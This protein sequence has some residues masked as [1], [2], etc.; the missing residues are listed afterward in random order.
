MRFFWILTVGL[1]I[2]IPTFLLAGSSLQFNNQDSSGN[3]SFSFDESGTKINST[4]KYINLSTSTIKN[5]TIN[6]VGFANLT[7]N[8]SDTNAG[9]T[10]N[11]YASWNGSVFGNP[12]GVLDSQFVTY[13]FFTYLLNGS[14]LDSGGDESGIISRHNFTN[15]SF[16]LATSKMPTAFNGSKL[17]L[18]NNTGDSSDYSTFKLM[19]TDFP[20]N[21]INITDEFSLPLDSL[22]T[23]Q[24]M[25]FAPPN[26]LYFKIGQTTIAKYDFL[27]GKVTENITLQ[28]PQILSLQWDGLT[29]WVSGTTNNLLSRMNPDNLSQVDFNTSTSPDQDGKLIY[30]NKDLY[31]WTANTIYRKFIGRG[32]PSDLKINVGNDSTVEYT[33]LSENIKNTTT[34]YLGSS[35]FNN[36]ISSNCAKELVNKNCTIP[37][38]INSTSGMWSYSNL[39]ITQNEVP[40][41]T[42][43]SITPLPVSGGNTLTGHY[44]YSDPDGDSQLDV[45]SYWYINKTMVLTANNTR[46]LLSGNVT[47]FSNITFSA[48]FNDSYDWGDWVNSSTI[49]V[50]DSTP[51]TLSSA[52]VSPTSGTSSSNINISV[53]CTDLSAIS[54]VTVTTNNTNVHTNHSMTNLGDRWQFTQTYGD[55]SYTIPY[56]YCQD[57]STNLVIG[58][59]NL[60]FTISTP[61]GST[62]GGGGGGGS[63]PLPKKDCSIF[64]TPEQFEFSSNNNIQLLKLE[65]KESAISYSP[66]YNIPSGFLDIRGQLEQIIIAGKT[67]EV[68]FVYS[69]F[70]QN[71]TEIDLTLQS[72]VCKDIII[73]ITLLSES[74]KPSSFVSFEE[75]INQKLGITNAFGKPFTFRLYHLTGIYA[76]TI[77]ITL[78]FATNVKFVVKIPIF[79]F[80]TLG[81]TLFSKLILDFL[82]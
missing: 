50:G 43:V 35:G 68:T 76:L 30:D 19:K 41:A 54:F 22:Q 64:L 39:N 21:P 79:L 34:I 24:P 1:L 46:T 48:R 37:I 6:M 65:N 7:L 61:T 2:I 31:V 8:L 23:N 80:S 59:S 44:N 40:N 51:P 14:Q 75:Y 38:I 58:A 67:S 36:Y 16:G 70:V 56:F 77:F 29:L 71:K 9:R 10:R 63:S 81:L 26:I 4:V 49:T 12:T 74:D 32:F 69:N 72:E 55:G 20:N 78:L 53:A 57:T 25:T 13:E 66:T 52:S 47:D 60:V 62:S 45:Q 27:Q 11:T 5:A 15:I 17:W 73:P 33:N 18:I 42:N 28:V 3:I 82:I